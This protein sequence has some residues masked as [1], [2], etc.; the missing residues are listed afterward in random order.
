MLLADSVPLRWADVAEKTKELYT[1]GLHNFLSWAR[2][3]CLHV[4]GDEIDQL[5]D[6]FELHAN[7]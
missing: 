6:A 4:A 7:E 2:E 5:D 1:Q 3:P